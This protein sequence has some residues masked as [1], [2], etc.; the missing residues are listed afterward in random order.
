[1]KTQSP[2]KIFLYCD[3]GEF[4][5]STLS[6]K[7]LGGSETAGIQIAKELSDLGNEVTV[8]SECTGLNTSPGVYDGVAYASHHNFPYISS[9][10]SHDVNIISRRH[11][12]LL[13]R[14]LSKINILWQEELAFENQKQDFLNCIWNADLIFA[15][16]EFHKNQQASVWNLPEDFFWIAGNGINIDLINDSIKDISAR[17]PKKL[18]YASRPE[19]GLDVLLTKIFPELLKHDSELKLYI[20]TYDFFPPQIAHLISQLKEFSKQFGDSVVWL[21]PLNKV[22][23]YQHL[24]TSWLYVYPTNHEENYMILAAEAQACGLPIVTRNVGAIPNVMDSEAGYILNGFDSIY[25]PV[26]Q[27]QF[28]FRVLDLLNDTNKWIQASLKAKE[29]ALELD[30]K[31]NAKRWDSKFRE[32]IDN[33]SKS[34]KIQP[35]RQSVDAILTTRNSEDTLVSCL[36]SL[37]SHVDNIIV[38]D[39]ESTDTTKE[40][41]DEYKCTILNESM[42]DFELYGHEWLRNK[43]LNISKADW[44]FWIS[45]KDKIINGDNIQKYTRTGVYSGFSIEQKWIKSILTKDN[46]FDCPPRLFRRDKDIG[47]QGMIYERPEIE[48]KI[49]TIK[50]VSILDIGTDDKANYF[51]S[52]FTLLERDQQ[53]YPSRIVGNVYFIRDL[54]ILIQKS[55]RIPVDIIQRWC[56]LII[57]IY[58]KHF[59]QS[60]YASYREVLLPYSMANESL[61]QGIDFSWNFDFDR[62]ESK[63]N[64]SSSRAR[65]SSVEKAKVYLSNIIERQT[66]PLLSKYYLPHGL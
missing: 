62:I 61:G 17:D 4:D 44:I 40:I 49:G 46:Y 23:L 21:P 38:V 54:A 26:F 27:Q 52:E 1:V 11:Q 2:L 58:E 28:I 31:E 59:L 14:K 13:S 48:G 50:D 43:C 20:T 45:P 30:W 64:G 37:V 22:E 3:G 39:L 60:E 34:I 65:F 63:L 6:K 12:L 33:S 10:I 41:L 47:F 53:K 24:C 35:Q 29:K 55:T 56:H 36:A 66:K 25:N 42:E 51:K 32:L 9:H 18:I 7:S 15:L 57:D 16:T 19:R 5:G 8:F